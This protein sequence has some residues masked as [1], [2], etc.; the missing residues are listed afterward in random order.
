M[1]LIVQ[2]E[3]RNKLSLKY[4]ESAIKLQNKL[5]DTIPKLKAAEKRL[6]ILI[7]RR[8]KQE[9]NTLKSECNI[10]IIV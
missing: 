10:I 6:K 9:K 5:D 1:L 2:I 7:Y 3:I 4:Y 8:E